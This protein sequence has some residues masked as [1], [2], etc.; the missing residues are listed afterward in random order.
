MQKSVF[1]FRANML[2]LCKTINKT[3]VSMIKMNFSIDA[4]NNVFNAQWAFEPVAK[5]RWSKGKHDKRGVKNCIHLLSKSQHYE[6]VKGVP[7]KSFIWLISFYC[8]AKDYNVVFYFYIGFR[9]TFSWFIIRHLFV[10]YAC[11]KM[12]NK[13]FSNTERKL[14]STSFS[15]MIS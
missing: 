6:D 8:T 9:H 5:I 11:M 15:E 12:V 3:A 4:I 10:L 1:Q 7:E 14:F 13:I 2:V